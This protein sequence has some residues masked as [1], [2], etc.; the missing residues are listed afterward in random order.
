MPASSLFEKA[1]SIAIVALTILVSAL[2]MSPSVADPDLWGHVQFGRDFLSTGVLETTTSYSFTADGYRWINHENLSEI[3]LA[4]TVENY[5]PLGL[6]WG[7]FLLSLFVIGSVL[8]F[9]FRRQVSLIPNCALTILVAWNLGYHWSFRPQLLTFFY[10][11]LM[12]ILLQFAFTGWK[13]NWHLKWFRPTW[14]TRNDSNDEIDYRWIHSRLLWLAPFLFCLWTNSHGGF[15]AGVCIY[16]AY[17]G[18]RA[19]EALTSYWP[20]GWGLVRRMSLMIVV[21]ILAT[22]VNPYSYRLPMW[23]FE[24][25]GT[26]RPEILDWSSGQLMSLVGFKFWA[27]VAISIGALVYSRKS[28]DFTQTVILALTLW[29]AFS[30]FR[31]VPFFAILAGF[32]VGPH[33]QSAF[34]RLTQGASDTA[35][36]FSSKGKLAVATVMVALVALI[37]WRLSDR[38]D[39]LKV[40]KQVFPVDAFQYIHDNRLGGRLVVTYDW[41]Q[42]SI[43]AM[44]VEENLQPGQPLSR[45]AFDGRFRTC[46]PQPIVDMHFDLLFGDQMD[47]SRSDESGRID[48]TRVLEYGTPDLVLIKRKGELSESVLTSQTENWALLFQDG[49]AQL[50]GRRTKYDNPQSP[51]FVPKSNR[52]IGT[53]LPQGYVD[54]PA[55]PK[56]SMATS[57]SRQV[58]RLSP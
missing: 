53:E 40:D 18:C 43:A 7:K 44:C 1:T 11:T 32:W 45:V 34:V 54:W 16:V 31:H 17:L 10:F 46:Y 21:A 48:P 57:R 6:V 38:L 52:I 47:R 15:A 25:L 56:K 9:N 42:Y 3:L 55:L 26:P 41:A 22:F 36:E 29:Q 8:W 33:L 20:K 28:L 2:A 12:V 30:H 50:W 4:W 37:G 19:I 27:L 51:D 39:Q 13:D 14:L 58:V 35:S 23:L 5:G 49:M 24:S